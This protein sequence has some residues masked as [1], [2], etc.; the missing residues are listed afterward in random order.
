M[1]N[2]VQ[3]KRNNPGLKLSLSPK[4]K[5]CYRFRVNKVK[6]DFL[7][8]PARADELRKLI[9]DIITLK[10]SQEDI[11]NWYNAFVAVYHSEMNLFYKQLE[12]TPKSKKNYLILRKS[13]WNDDLGEPAKETRDKRKKSLHFL[14]KI[15]GAMRQIGSLSHCRV[16]LIN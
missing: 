7:G 12:D 2:L 10:A 13:W 14:N 6:D 16:I 1:K 15:E 3:M 5:A 11:N 9:N 8:S 4:A